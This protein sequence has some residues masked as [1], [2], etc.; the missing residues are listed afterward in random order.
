MDYSCLQFGG[1]R[2]YPMIPVRLMLFLGY[3]SECMNAQYT[4][5][6]RS[7]QYVELLHRNIRGC[8]RRRMRTCMDSVVR[9]AVGQYGCWQLLF[10][11]RQI[12]RFNDQWNTLTEHGRASVTTTNHVGLY[13]RISDDE[14]FL[15]PP[16]IPAPNGAKPI[17]LLRHR[18][19]RLNIPPPLTVIPPGETLR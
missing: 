10:Y 6:N 7:Y 2:T 19:C 3:G 4:F 12:I 5:Q 18:M 13:G 9:A 15:N 11:G 17:Y 1:G 16:T 14:E 8:H